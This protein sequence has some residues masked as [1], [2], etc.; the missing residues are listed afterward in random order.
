MGDEMAAALSSA[1]DALGVPGNPTESGLLGV[2]PCLATTS[3]SKE[4][5]IS[6]C[7]FAVESGYRRL[8]VDVVDSPIE[9]VRTSPSTLPPTD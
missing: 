7:S 5:W 8:D 2:P 9:N 6:R 1:R 4:W 3:F